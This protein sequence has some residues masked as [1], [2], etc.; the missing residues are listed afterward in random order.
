MVSRPSHY[1]SASIADVPKTLGICDVEEGSWAALL[2]DM[3]LILR[4]R[5]RDL[6]CHP[7]KS[8]TW[9]VGEKARSALFHEL[10]IAWMED[11]D[12]LPSANVTMARR[13]FA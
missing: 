2:V 6:S 11:K 10:C 7:T 9:N 4:L 13:K 1:V 12:Q 3:T 5:Y 8:A